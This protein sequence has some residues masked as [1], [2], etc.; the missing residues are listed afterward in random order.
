LN[1]APEDG[2]EGADLH[3]VPASVW[4]PGKIV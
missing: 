2:E 1:L 3:R 4:I